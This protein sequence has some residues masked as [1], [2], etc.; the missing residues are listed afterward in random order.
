MPVYV[1][2]ED[3][4]DSDGNSGSYVVR[5]DAGKRYG[6]HGSRSQAERQRDAI[7]ANLDE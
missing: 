7:N 6:C 4:T 5:D 1:T 2:E 3:C